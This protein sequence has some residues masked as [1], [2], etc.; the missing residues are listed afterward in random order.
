MPIDTDES[1]TAL[2]V[3]PD[4]GKAL[5]AVEQTRLA[6]VSIT[7]L[8]RI[9][10]LE[11]HEFG[12]T[13]M[14]DVTDSYDPTTI[15]PEGGYPEGEWVRD[16]MSRELGDPRKLNTMDWLNSVVVAVTDKF[17]EKG[18][19]RVFVGVHMIDPEDPQILDITS[20]ILEKAGLVRERMY[21]PMAIDSEEVAFNIRDVFLNALDE[22]GEGNEDIREEVTALLGDGDE[23]DQF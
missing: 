12:K 2:S 17:G 11:H 9:V 18:V 5:L 6:E 16:L 8:G 22:V 1:A 3:M 23:D 7:R 13:V 4:T 15:Y 21:V 14:V 19:A 10:M 20:H